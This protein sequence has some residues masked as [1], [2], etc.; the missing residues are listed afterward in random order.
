MRFQRNQNF[1]NRAR[2]ECCAPRSNI[3]SKE[4]ILDPGSFRRLQL[5]RMQW[6]VHKILCM[7]QIIDLNLAIPTQSKFWKSDKN[8]WLS[9]RIQCYTQER[10]SISQVFSPHEAIQHAVM[11][12]PNAFYLQSHFTLNLRPKIHLFMSALVPQPAS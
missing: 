7:R 11:C 10:N 12:T 6:W 5:Y 3:I 8:W 2:I 1:E 4:E 9:S